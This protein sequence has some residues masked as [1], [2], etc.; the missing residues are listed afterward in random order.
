MPRVLYIE[1]N[2]E[3]RMLVRRVL[4]ASD[5]NFTVEEAED[6]KTG[7]ALAKQQRPDV[8]LM[9]LSM[10]DMD[11]LAATAYLRTLPGFDTLPIVALTANVMPGD[12]ERSI[13]A[14]CDGHIG[15]PIDV[16]TLAETVASYLRS[17]Q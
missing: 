14:G 11:G 3:N 2:P 10:P 16:D 6:A 4:M 1:D 9:D 5:Y 15:K 17:H 12:A 8:I 7:I 13:E